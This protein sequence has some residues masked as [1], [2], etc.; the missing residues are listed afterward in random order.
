MLDKKNFNILNYVRKEEYTGSM[1]GM[2]YMVKKAGDEAEVI[3]WPEP[4]A[5]AYTDEEMKQRKM[6][7]LSDEGMMMICDYLNEQ[8]EAQRP[9][10]ELSKTK[11]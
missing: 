3:I 8:Y 7:P 11:K 10:W 5:Y 4:F 2:R 1:D 6:F 9:L